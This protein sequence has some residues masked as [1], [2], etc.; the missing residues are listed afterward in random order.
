M[1]KHR[2]VPAPPKNDKGKGK[3]KGKGKQKGDRSRTPSPHKGKG[4]KKQVPDVPLTD[5]GNRYFFEATLGRHNQ[6]AKSKPCYFFQIGRC[7]KGKACTHKHIKVSKEEFDKMELPRSLSPSGKGKGKT[8]TSQDDQG[9]KAA[10]RGKGDGA[11][12]VAAAVK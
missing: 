10:G 4:P 1:K 9:G 11:T 8:K 2:A 6:P 3:G 12:Q 7:T 5:E